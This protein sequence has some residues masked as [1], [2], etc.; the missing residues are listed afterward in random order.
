MF[1]ELGSM[2]G[3]SGSMFAEFGSKSASSGSMFAGLGSKSGASGSKCGAPGAG[4]G[5]SVDSIYKVYA[6]RVA[7]VG[8]KVATGASKKVSGY[9]RPLQAGSSSRDHAVGGSEAM[10]EFLGLLF[11]HLQGQLP[12]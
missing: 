6:R 7:A 4:A 2:F 11:P 1:E 10:A 3:S 8:C 5:V 12:R 9:Q